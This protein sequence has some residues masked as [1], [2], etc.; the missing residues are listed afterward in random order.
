MCLHQN[1]DFQNF[2]QLITCAILTVH[3]RFSALKLPS[4][5]GAP[6]FALSSIH[7]PHLNFNHHLGKFLPSSHKDFKNRGCSHVL[8][9]QAIPTPT[10]TSVEKG[11]IIERNC[12]KEIFYG[13]FQRCLALFLHIY[14]F[15]PL[16]FP[17]EIHSFIFN[18]KLDFLRGSIM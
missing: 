18:H 1:P 16:I 9:V 8:Q 4:T 7:K 17:N 10:R 13:I 3:S 2:N 5:P 14:F 15:S 11:F 6:F 12:S